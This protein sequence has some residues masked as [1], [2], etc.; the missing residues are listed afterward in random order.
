MKWRYRETRLRRWINRSRQ[1]SCDSRV[2]LPLLPKRAGYFVFWLEP[3]KQGWLEGY[4]DSGEGAWSSWLR[5]RPKHHFAGLVY[6][7]V[8]WSWYPGVIAG[9]FWGGI[10]LSGF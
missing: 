4:S 1:D 9:M 6:L 3:V 8:Y 7:L 10:K 2:I 5:T